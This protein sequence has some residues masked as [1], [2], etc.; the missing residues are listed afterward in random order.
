MT[1][2]SMIMDNLKFVTNNCNGLATSEKDRIKQFLY[3]QNII[4]NIGILFL[5]ETHSTKDSEKKFQENFGKN[6]ELY[7]GHGS[8]NSCGVAI[9]F[10]GNF[11]RK[12]EKQ[13]VDPK[14]RYLL[15]LATIGDS[16]Y[17]LINIYNDNIEKDQLKTLQEV[18][19]KIEQLDI[20][21]DTKVVLAGDFNFYFNKELEAVGG[22]PKTKVQSIASFL[23]IKEKYNLVDIWRIQ[24]PKEKRYT[25]RQ[26]RITGK[27]KRRLDF[28]FISDH[29]Q[30]SVVNTDIKVAMCTD[31]SPVYMDLSLEN[32]H[33]EKGRG[34]W[35]Y[36]AS[37]NK[38]PLYKE[39]I[40]PL[41]RNFLNLNRDLD[42]QLK[43]E[44][45]KYEV[46]I[47]TRRYTKR[48]AKEKKA[49]RE[50][51]EKK[52]TS[53]NDADVDP[54][55]E[56]YRKT[57]EDL[58]KIYDDI[59]I[60]IRVRSKCNWYESGEKSNKYF[61]NL[62][63]KN[64]ITSTI[65]KLTDDDRSITNQKDVLSSIEKFY[66]NLFTNKNKNSSESCKNFLQDLQNPTLNEEDQRALSN[67]LSEDELYL[68]LSEMQDGKSPG[69][70]GLSCEFY[71]EFWEDIKSPFI[72]SIF[73]AKA[74]GQLSSSQRQ[75]IIRL[76]EKRD[77]DKTKI[78]NW[79]PISLLNVDVKIL[80]KTLAK[81]LKEVLSKIICSNQTAY[82]K[83]RF[84]G[85]GGRLI[86]DLLEMTDEL[87]MDGII[88]TIDFQ[89][90]FDSLNHNFITESCQKFGIP[91]NMINW[92]KIMLKNQESCVINGGTTT[93]YFKLERGA[94]QGDPIAAYLFIIAL[95]ILFL[96]IKNNDDIKPL[97]LCESSFLYTAYADDAT[98][99]LQDEYSV[100]ALFATM[101]L[102]SNFS[103]LKPNLDKCE[104]AGIGVLKGV[105]WALCGLKSVDLTQQTIKILGIHFSYNKNLS[106]ELNFTNIV[107]K[108]E[109]LLRIWCQRSLTLEGKITVFK[110]LAISMVV[111]IAYLSSVPSYIIKE[112]KKIQNH[113][114]W[115]GKRA[116][117]KH[118]TLSN[119]Y[120]NGGLQS[121]DIDLKIK[122]LQLSWFHRLFDQKEHQWKTI[123]RYLF[124]KKFG[125]V[126][127]FSHHF[128][129]SKEL[130]SSIPTFYQNI[131]I[132]WKDVSS[133]PITSVPILN[134]HIWHNHFLKI[135]EKSFY[136][137]EFANANLNYVYQLFHPDGSIKNW[138]FLKQEFNLENKSYFRCIQLLHSIPAQWRQTVLAG[139][140]T[141][142]DIIPAQGILQCTIIIPMEKLTSKQIYS[143]LIRKR[144]HT[145]TSKAYYDTKFPCIE[146]NWPKIYMLTKK[147]T[148]NAYDRIFQYKILNNTLFLN[149]KLFLFGISHTS[150]CSFCANEDEDAT[151]IFA[152]CPRSVTLWE[153]L[154]Q[155]F[156][157]HLL[158]P[159]LND[160]AALLG[161]YEA[162]P[163]R[164][165][166][167][168]HT[169]LLFKLHIYQRR[170]YGTLN[171]DILLKRIYDTAKLELS[172][173][174]IGSPTQTYY[175]NKWR[176][177]IN[178]LNIN[179][180]AQ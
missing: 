84:I 75:A 169:L 150:R 5:Q 114:L 172:L 123:P 134:Q 94:R 99:F 105:T 29:L 124:L 118:E 86:S 138:N 122:A 161:F 93:K 62:E 117:I 171:L 90:A 104:I 1:T 137:K 88:L 79:R 89:K 54:D 45:L 168:N 162:S 121:V 152:N 13:I 68:A 98:F 72:D 24:H 55:D 30:T 82:V 135:G 107:K 140:A 147:T 160:K 58:D 178:L 113:F 65:T 103:D 34:F 26:N 126:N 170:D 6:N 146:N 17:A 76:I 128:S 77:K 127:I 19:E 47:F 69:N 80:S 87:K 163:E 180:I 144:A 175:A 164:L 9:G 155:A 131:L 8:S 85:E 119:S 28:I 95:E 38:D 37:L 130:L 67:D 7:F 25:F 53:L 51:L 148:K 132:A 108:I 111:Y 56:D 174:V 63:K 71:K 177:L 115:N 91:E 48:L 151:H 92:I 143:I 21:P 176:P 4:K 157:P 158:I 61:L 57:R 44:L 100:K 23:K 106:D 145:P 81:R 83:D 12:I 78:G 41:I 116:K 22:N 112:V 110:T 125:C 153:G 59:A 120:E 27:L 139:L 32:I 136:F 50:N 156:S 39:E 20:N 43:W 46:K 64:A 2:W 133:G 15:I 167:I 141:P 11:E 109:T 179:Q 36:N 166:L 14:G 31:H 96:M 16:E 60:G 52:L 74:C 173:A 165:L 149:K 73:H 35:K 42:K 97:S 3:L 18:I 49:N 102:F 159:N 10:C 33:L 40:R 142:N 101:K 154:K 129:P 66:K 70:D